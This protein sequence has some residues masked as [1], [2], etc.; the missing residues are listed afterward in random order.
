MSRDSHDSPSSQLNL[1]LRLSLPLVNGY[2]ERGQWTFWFVTPHPHSHF[3]GL[4]HGKRKS[5]C[6]KCIRTT[7]NWFCLYFCLV[8]SCACFLKPIVWH[9]IRKCKINYFST[10][11]N[12]SIPDNGPFP[13]SL[14]PLFQNEFKC[15]T[16]YK[17]WVLHAVSLIH[18]HANQS[19]I[20]RMVCT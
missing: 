19:F 17:K 2:W 6:G 1:V 10:N 20:V 15:K 5:S 7:H 12:C 18:F 8:E 14:V 13:S 9:K 3:E 16:S 11:E 4:W